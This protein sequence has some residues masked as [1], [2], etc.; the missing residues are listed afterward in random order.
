MAIMGLLMPVAGLVK[1]RYR[2]AKAEIDSPFFKL[3]YRTTSTILFIS[4]LLVTCND[5]I[6]S[7]ISCINDSVP[8]NVLNTYCWIMSTFSIPSQNKGIDGIDRP[9]QGIGPETGDEEDRKVHAYYQWVPF[10]LFLQGVMFYI[11]HYLWKTFE[12]KKM[13][14][15][16]SGLRGKTFSTEGRREA[17]EHLISY[18]W[19]TRGMH[20]AYALKYFVCDILNFVNV[21]GQ[22]Y[23]INLFLG[24][25]FMTYGTEVLN[26]INMDDE[27]RIARGDPMMEVFPRVTKCTFHK[28]GSSGTI[29]KLDA[30]C[31]L[32]LNIINEKIYITLWFWF[33]ILAIL[34]ACYTV[35]IV[36]LISMPSLRRSLVTRKANGNNKDQ[37]YHL[38]DKA[39]IGDWFMLFLVSKNMD[40][41]TYNIFIEELAE[42]FKTKA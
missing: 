30:L 37:A 7:T 3:H 2:G 17:C 23:F 1:A 14:K 21:I 38:V 42:K 35:Y 27:E 6:G 16:T 41:S 8:G 9:H 36:A 34:T 15:I 25:V 26:F 19:E 13:D 39:D 18:L 28:Y 29:M 12:D 33:V 11:P 31:V 32:G 24:G 4:C 40:S 20:K 5:L 22:M 10:M